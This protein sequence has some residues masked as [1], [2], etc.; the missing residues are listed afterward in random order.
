MNSLKNR[1]NK[2]A[3][4]AAAVTAAVAVSGPV[5]SANAAIVHSGI[6]N[7]TIA[8][9]TNGLYL[10][11]VTGAINEPG[12]GPGS[13]VPGWDVNFWSSTGFGLFNASG[14]GG[15]YVLTSTGWA[16][17]MAPGASIGAGLLYGSGTSG[18]NSQWNLNS[19][20]NLV[21]F[22]FVNEANGNAIHYGWARISFGATVTSRSLVEYAYE[23]VAGGSIGAGAVPAPAAMALLGMGGLVA[24]RRRRA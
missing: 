23:D 4:S 5:S 21:G 16:S 22:R 18:N 20:Q 6:V 2:Y 13:T 17:N 12:N 11:V 10:N 8:A 1:L 14:P 19:D 9:T 7:Q 3:A 24:A 15:T